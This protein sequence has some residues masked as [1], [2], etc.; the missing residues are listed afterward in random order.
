MSISCAPGDDVKWSDLRQ[1]M[2]RIKNAAATLGYSGEYESPLD[3]ETSPYSEAWTIDI[4][5]YQTFNVDGSGTITASYLTESSESTTPW[6]PSGYIETAATLGDLIFMADADGCWCKTMWNVVEGDGA[7]QLEATT[8]TS[9]GCCQTIPVP[10]VGDVLDGSQVWIPPRLK[11]MTMTDSDW[12]ETAKCSG[13]GSGIFYLGNSSTKKLVTAQRY[14]TGHLTLII[15]KKHFEEILTEVKTLS[16]LVGEYRSA[17]FL[18]IPWQCT[19][20][21]DPCTQTL[22]P[23]TG[24]TLEQWLYDLTTD[25]YYSSPGVTL[26]GSSEIVDKT[27]DD[28]LF[29]DPGCATTSEDCTAEIIL[30][31]PWTTPTC[32]GDTCEDSNKVYCNTVKWMWELANVLD[33]VLCP[34]V[35]N[36]WDNFVLTCTLT[37]SN[38][39]YTWTPGSSSGSSAKLKVTIDSFDNCGSDISYNTFSGSLGVSCGRYKV[40]ATADGTGS[41]YKCD[42][43]VE[44]CERDC[45]D[46]ETGIRYG[47]AG[48]NL[49]A[50]TCSGSGDCLIY[51]YT[52]PGTC[53]AGGNGEF[54]DIDPNPISGI[55]LTQADIQGGTDFLSFDV[56]DY[57]QYGSGTEITYT[58]S[59][60]P[61]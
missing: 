27:F 51:K 36:D 25:M 18:G 23:P 41:T 22:I 13:N 53:D 47:N 33:Y 15:R 6:M 28:A 31:R 5:L 16:G 44:N 26:G 34:K 37:S 40:T 4:E 54:M 55:T 52:G 48:A 43:E 46:P 38:V 59:I 42:C 50:Y 2:Q 11:N 19:T 14:L 29:N 45:P 3:K 57:S 1:I 60:T 21:T 17:A 58:I 9:L 35:E 49:F 20:V 10:V 7:F 56:W 12:H 61:L 32:A 30:P 39:N 8:G 24:A